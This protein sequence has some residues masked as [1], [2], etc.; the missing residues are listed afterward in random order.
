MLDYLITLALILLVLG[1]GLL[2]RGCFKINDA[3]PNSMS[4]ISGTIRSDF[5]AISGLLA[6]AVM[7]L[8]EVATGLPQNSPNSPPNPIESI[9][10]GLIS[11]I[12]MGNPYA[13]E[14]QEREIY[15]ADTQTQNTE[16]NEFA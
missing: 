1:H 3:I 15:E 12:D 16:I 13:S 11:N 6:D 2:I 14:K 4:E 7:I 5:E 10:T 9:L 8:D